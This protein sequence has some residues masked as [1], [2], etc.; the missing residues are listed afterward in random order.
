MNIYQMYGKHNNNKLNILFSNMPKIKCYSFEPA[1]IKPNNNAFT[2]SL[3]FSS[4]NHQY[5]NPNLT[6]FTVATDENDASKRF[7]LSCDYYG[8]KYGNIGARYYSEAEIWN[9]DQWAKS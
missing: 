2:D 7:R 9:L 5:T 8:Y 6:I 1:L 3:T 4:Y